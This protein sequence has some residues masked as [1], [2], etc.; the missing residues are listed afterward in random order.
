MNKLSLI[1]LGFVAAV[2]IAIGIFIPDHD[3]HQGWWSNIPCFY[4]LFG[5]IGCLI[6]IFIAK[7]I[8]NLFLY[9]REDYYD[10]D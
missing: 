5:F 4:A 2:S 6:L 9:K 8:G 10:A 3:I 7:S 1:L